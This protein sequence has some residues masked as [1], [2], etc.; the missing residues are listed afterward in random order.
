[1][2][3][4]FEINY[5]D[6]D[7]INTLFM[8]HVKA[9]IKKTGAVG[10]YDDNTLRPKAYMTR[11]EML[12]KIFDSLISTY[13]YKAGTY[14]IPEDY[15]GIVVINSKDVTVKKILKLQIHFSSHKL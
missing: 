3:E 15:S 4:E 12:K 13:I 10:G 11:A 2:D 6:K 1:M 9:V 8:N 14:K 7:K 5:D